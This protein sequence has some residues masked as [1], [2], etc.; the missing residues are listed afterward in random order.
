MPRYC[1]FGDT[2]NTASRNKASYMTYSSLFLSELAEPGPIS[3]VKDD[4]DPSKPC[5]SPYLD[6]F[7]RCLFTVSVE[8][9]LKVPIY[10]TQVTN[11]FPNVKFTH[12]RIE[13]GIQSSHS[14][15]VPYHTICPRSSGL[16]YIISYYMKSLPLGHTVLRG[17]EIKEF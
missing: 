15:A 9:T 14:S 16:F 12:L 2:V 11:K 3:Y 5:C 4:P 1:L 13:S 6:I 7:Q 8:I 10:I 17:R